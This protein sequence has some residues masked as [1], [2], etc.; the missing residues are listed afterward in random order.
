MRPI[1]VALSVAWGCL[2]IAAGAVGGVLAAVIS[3]S[4][5]RAAFTSAV[6]HELRT[7]LTT[8]RMYTE[9]LAEGMIA[10]EHKRREYLAT[11]HSEAV[12]LGHLVENVLAYAR[13]E[14]GRNGRPTEI[15]DV[16]AVLDRTGERLRQR[17]ALAGMTLLVP[18]A[19]ALSPMP[20]RVDMSAVE[21][22]LSNLVDNA[23]KYAG[24]AADKS[25]HLEVAYE[26]GRAVIRVRDHGAGIRDAD[27][28]RLFRPFHKSAERAAS[29]APGVGLGL[30]LSRRLARALGG[31]LRLCREV[32]DGA[33]FE[34]VLA[35]AR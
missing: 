25:I 21:Q 3:L 8:F 29:T 1:H 18:D 28:R 5:R 14:R 17:A 6:T 13:L 22:I 31:D 33:C 24:G 26:A 12:R 7:P 27:A 9:I 32:K 23:C 20:V 34:L 30:A 19:T 35:R 4:E 11:L 2:V 10:D 16:K 15:A